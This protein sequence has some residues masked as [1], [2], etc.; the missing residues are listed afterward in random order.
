MIEGG[1][2]RS[3]GDNQVLNIKADR[4][5]MPGEAPIAPAGCGP[6]KLAEAV[7]Y[8]DFLHHD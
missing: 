2:N 5:G 6:D 3:C 4:F 8:S 7:A 1:D